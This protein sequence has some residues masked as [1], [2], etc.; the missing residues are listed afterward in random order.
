MPLLN[1]DIIDIDTDITCEESAVFASDVCLSKHDRNAKITSP[2]HDRVD[3][4]ANLSV[5]KLAMI[6]A[7]PL[8]IPAP[9][10]ITGIVEV[11]S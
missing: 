2:I 8:R 6:V 3:L 10:S 11:A 5:S 4:A 1:Y 7:I 9:L